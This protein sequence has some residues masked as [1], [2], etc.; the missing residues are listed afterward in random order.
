ML[1]RRTERRARGGVLAAL[2]SETERGL[3]R[4][5]FLRRSGV[6][7]G[8]L[9]GLGTLPLASVRK[10]AAGPPPIASAQVAIRKSVCT[11]CAV[12]CTVTAEI[13][14]GVE[15]QSR[16][17]QPDQPW[18]TAK[19]PRRELVSGERRLKY[20]LKLVGGE[21]TRLRDQ[22]NN[23]IGDKLLAIRE[24]SGPIWFIARL[25]EVHQ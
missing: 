14:N 7:A 1:I 19:A 10:A 2:A 21:W 18:V 25:G 20:P 11:H 5:A 17:G 16:A 6:V 23:E 12:G 8:G 4:R 9:A 3:D 24:K 13:A 15:G 22:A